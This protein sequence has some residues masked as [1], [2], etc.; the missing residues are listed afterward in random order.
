M[1][2][3]AIYPFFRGK[4]GKIAPGTIYPNVNDLPV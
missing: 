2:P 4:L 3:G 1:V